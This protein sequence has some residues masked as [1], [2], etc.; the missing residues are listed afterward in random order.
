V[1]VA[2]WG[3]QNEGTYSSENLTAAD[4]A[5]APDPPSAP[6]LG[7]DYAT[8][9]YTQCSYYRAF[10]VVAPRVKA[11]FPAIKI[12]ANSARGQLGASPLAS[13]PAMAAL[14]DLWTWHFVG[15][16]GTTPLEDR[17]MLNSGTAGKPVANNEYEYQPGSP[18]AGTPAGFM[19]TAHMILNFLTFVNSPTFYWI[20]ALKPTT[21]D[22]SKGEPAVTLAAE[23]GGGSPGQ[24]KKSGE[25]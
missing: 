17:V 7:D 14:V 2:W 13:D 6:G 1:Q 22:E 18:Y 24:G 5:H 25:E 12:H 9:A 11:A 3:L 19:N 10:Q 23:R 4:C 21:N 8:C 15:A 16:S 20:H